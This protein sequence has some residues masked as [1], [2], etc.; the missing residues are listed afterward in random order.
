MISF[1]LYIFF[2]LFT[3]VLFITSLKLLKDFTTCIVCGLLMMILGV[4]LLINVIN[5]NDLLLTSFSVITM[6][7]GFYWVVRCSIELNHDRYEPVNLFKA[8]WKRKEEKKK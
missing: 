4:Y 3:W 7:L 6:L 2:F 1:A 8:K 5:I